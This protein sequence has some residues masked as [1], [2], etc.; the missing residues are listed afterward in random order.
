MYESV[1]VPFFVYFDVYGV[2][3]VIECSLFLWSV[4]NFVMFI[5]NAIGN[6]IVETYS[7]IGL[8]PALSVE[9]NVSLHHMVEERTLSIVLEALS[10]FQCVCCE[11]RIERE[12]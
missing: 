1:S 10:V 12:C 2:F 7:S 11:F 3:V 5:V 6:H 8:G 4:C 9:G